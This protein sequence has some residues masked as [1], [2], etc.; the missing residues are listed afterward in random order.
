MASF[1]PKSSSAST[2]HS[3][4]L[5]TPVGPASRID[6]TG[7]DSSRMPHSPRQ[8]QSA[9]C[10]TLSSC[11]TTRER[12]V[13]RS[14]SS[15]CRSSAVSFPTGI[16]V[17][18]E[19]AHAT[20][21]A[22]TVRALRRLCSRW[23]RFCIR[24]RRAA[25]VSYRLSRTASWSSCSSS[26]RKGLRLWRSRESRAWLAASSTRSM[27]LSG[28]YRSC[29]YRRDMR[30]ASCSVSSGSFSPWCCSSPGRRACRIVMVSSGVGSRTSTGRNRRSRAGS[31]SMH[32]RYSSRV[33]AP[34]SCSSPLPSAGFKILAASMAPSAA[35]APTM[36]C[37]SS[38]KRI[39]SPLRRISDTRSRSRSSNSPR[40]LVPATRFAI[41]ML[42]SRLSRSWGGTFP[43]A[44][45]WASPS[46][47]AVLPTP[48]SPIRAGLFL[49][50]RLRIPMTVSISRSRPTTGSMDDALATRSSLNCSRSFMDVPSFLTF[51]RLPRSMSAV[52]SAS[53]SIPATRSAAAAPPFLLRVSASSRCSGPTSFAP[54]R[55]ASPV[56]CRRI[57]RA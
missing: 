26:S 54:S 39:T 51:G 32:L 12:T 42:M 23:E 20:S 36:V 7:L 29:R 1:V 55:S 15:F 48:G 28:R 4:V 25:A 34:S 5:P 41:L 46:A 45:R 3:S 10:R 24:S 17:R 13:F 44:I 50:A 33:V 40:Y 6:A 14:S 11:P 8:M 37:I 31:F 57:R 43:A 9:T 18:S 47:M 22:V 16:P 2:R 38:T 35:P 27:A 19:T 21:C 49:W 30:M 56:A 52:K 53:G